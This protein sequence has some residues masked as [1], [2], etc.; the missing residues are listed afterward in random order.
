M[1]LRISSDLFI[2]TNVILPT[3]GN[4]DITTVL[5]KDPSPIPHIRPHIFSKALVKGD[6][7]CDNIHVVEKVGIEV[8]LVK[9]GFAQGILVGNIGCCC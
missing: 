8:I 4:T 9:K 1:L 6:M 3:H 7:G 5:Q 2:V